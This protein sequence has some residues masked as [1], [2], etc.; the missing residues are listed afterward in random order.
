MLLVDILKCIFVAIALYFL[1][2]YLVGKSG[3]SLAVSFI[4]FFISGIFLKAWK[5]KNEQ[6]KN[7]I[8]EHNPQL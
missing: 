5:K 8:H 4:G 7:F 1:T 6:A 3:I 2:F